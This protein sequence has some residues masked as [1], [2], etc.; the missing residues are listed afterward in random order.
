MT[1]RA[2]APDEITDAKGK[3]HHAGW[4]IGSTAYRTA[5]CGLE[6]A[7]EGWNGEN[8]VRADGRTEAEAW[9][10]AFGQAQGLGMLGGARP[11]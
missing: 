6:W 3:L 9:R 10:A 11:G 7:V 5:A 4:S 1:D 2:G 8:I